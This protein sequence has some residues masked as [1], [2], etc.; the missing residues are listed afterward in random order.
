MDLVDGILDRINKYCNLHST[1]LITEEGEYLF[2]FDVVIANTSNS[3]L[4]FWNTRILN[5]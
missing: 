4:I 5:Y 1:I 3:T 2:P